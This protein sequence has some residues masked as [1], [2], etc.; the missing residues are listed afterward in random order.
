MKRIKTL[1]NQ[2]VT[3]VAQVR[4]LQAS[5]ARITGQTA[6]PS[7]CLLVLIMSLALVLA[8]T[9]QNAASSAD[10][11]EDEGISLSEDG[12]T[13]LNPAGIVN[14]SCIRFTLSALALPLTL[15]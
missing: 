13:S 8:P 5:L 2:K 3:L 11:A 10:S 14:T 15:A 4:K 7:T 1:E 9:I 12:S 6:Q